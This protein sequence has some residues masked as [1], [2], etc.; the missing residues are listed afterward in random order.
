MLIFLGVSGFRSTIH[1]HSH[2]RETKKFHI[3]SFIIGAI[4]GLAGSAAMV[5]LALTT[6]TSTI[7]ALSFIL[8]FGAGTILGMLLFTTVLGLPFVWFVSGRT[9]QTFAARAAAVLSVVYGIYYMY[10]I[11]F[12]DGL[13]QI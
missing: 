7:A 10:E 5:L 4:H 12:V 13:F 9:F 3:K 1:V 8:I 2:Q 6:V 11:T